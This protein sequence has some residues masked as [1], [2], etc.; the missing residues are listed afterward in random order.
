MALAIF[1][2]FYRFSLM[3]RQCNFEGREFFYRKSPLPDGPFP[4]ES[5][6]LCCSFSV[7]SKIA[8]NRYSG[9]KSQLR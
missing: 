9:R 7:F 4:S 6:N 2:A 1:W 8:C 3:S 5:L